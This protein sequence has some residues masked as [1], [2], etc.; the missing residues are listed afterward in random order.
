MKSR[1]F[2]AGS[3]GNHLAHALR[4]VGSHVEV[5]DIDPNALSR[6]RDQIY[7]T[8]Y[9]SWD[10]SINL[11]EH[12]SGDVVDLEII[13]TPPDTHASLI[14]QRVREQ[15]SKYWL[16]E[17]PC[18]PADTSLITQVNECIASY[19]AQVFVG[20]N[21]SVSPAFL[22]FQELLPQLPLLQSLH[23]FWLEHWDGIFKAH[24]WLSGPSDSYLG[25]TRRG[26]GSLSEHSHGLHLLLCSLG[27]L[28]FIK[29]HIG[30]A[31]VSL[32]DD[33]LHDQSANLKLVVDTDLDIR[34]STDVLST[35]TRKEICARSQYHSLVCT[36]G[37]DDGKS[38][39]VV[40]SSPD[41]TLEF[42]F[43]RTRVS[44]FEHEI[45]LLSS[46]S[47]DKSHLSNLDWTNATQVMLLI[48]DSLPSTLR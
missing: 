27:T 3:I 11:L 24:P 46:P 40:Y 48:A 25:Y 31:K 37:A 29:P 39:K 41:E 45:K 26:G 15:K 23:C 47:L 20:Y 4:N 44:D 9:G 34:Y 36:F 6:M 28:G 5:I 42:V 12:P 14:L 30:E 16:V 8:R 1:I 2:G 43:P 22:K 21:H 13:G 35:V 38:D 33:S 32:S 17:K 18:L 10:T 7:P 19:N